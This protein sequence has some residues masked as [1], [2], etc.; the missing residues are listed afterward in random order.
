[1][2]TCNCNS[3]YFEEQPSLRRLN[4]NIQSSKQKIVNNLIN[5]QMGNR[6]IYASNT[7]TMFNIR[8][9]KLKEL[10]R[11]NS[12]SNIAKAPYPEAYLP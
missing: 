9:N 4:L 5:H 2:T 8:E 11:I 12:L 10:S 3:S 7:K 1:M 6:G